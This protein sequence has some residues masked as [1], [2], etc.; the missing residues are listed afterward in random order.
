M[1]DLTSNPSSPTVHPFNPDQPVVTVPPV[2]QPP[3]AVEGDTA[4]FYQHT[5][6]TPPADPPS[7]IPHLGHVLLLLGIAALYLLAIQLILLGLGHAA[8][9]KP[10]ALSAKFL[11][12]SE[13]VSYIAT[14]A[15]AWVIFPLLWKRSFSEGVQL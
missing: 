12:G 14:L 5:E 3:E 15:T 9:A 8:P 7:R 1:S 4:L 6:G 2:F 11:V 10:G 13:A